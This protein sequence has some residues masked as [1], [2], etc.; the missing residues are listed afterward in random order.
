MSYQDIIR[1][2]TQIK[3]LCDDDCPKMAS[4][5]ISWLITDIKKHTDKLSLWDRLTSSNK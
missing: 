5:R 4:E 3:G 1:N 2:L